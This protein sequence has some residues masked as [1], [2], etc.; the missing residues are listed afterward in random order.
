MNQR[1]II[2]FL[3]L[4]LIV[5]TLPA[6]AGDK[7]VDGP[8]TETGDIAGAEFLIEIPKNW[9]GGLIMYAHGYSMVGTGSPFNTSMV[10][11]GHELGYA[12]AQSRYARQGWAAREGVLDTEALRRYFVNTYGETYP[13]II[14]GHSQGA[15]ITYYTIEHYPEYYDGAL[16]MCGTAEPALSFFKRRVFD[17]RLLFDYYFPGISG[18]VVDF[19]EGEKTFAK[20]LAKANELVKAHPEEAARFIRMVNLPD[21]QS[22]PGV[23][24][25]WSE[26]LRELQV[27]TGGNA[28]DNR[29]T[30]Y[31]GSDDDARLNRKISRYASDARSVEYLR[32]WVTIE[33]DARD[34]ILALHTLVDPLITATA[35]NAYDDLAVGQDNSDRF[36]MQYV[37]RIG[38][39]NFTDAETKA[40]LESLTQWIKRDKRPV[41]GEITRD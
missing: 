3:F 28:F 26:I 40:A 36:V 14:A 1:R 8:V 37:D 17:M 27:R 15:A 41:A 33:G 29:D 5:I 11:V 23:I 35:G 2:R 34:P 38:H 30:V 4:G 7:R 39:C 32:Q 22:I 16:P 21:V 10:R 19:P 13:T 9:N 25:F 12:V 20:A 6:F 24:A 18:S 31:E